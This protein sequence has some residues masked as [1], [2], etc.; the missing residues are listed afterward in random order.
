[1]RVRYLLIALILLPTLVYAQD[2]WG[3]AALVSDDYWYGFCDS[4]GVLYGFESPSIS[5]ND[6]LIF[7]IPWCFWHHPAAYSVFSEGVWQMPSTVPDSITGDNVTSL[8]Y[9]EQ[10]STLYFRSNRYPLGRTRFRDGIWQA[11]DSLASYL[12]LTGTEVDPSLPADGSRL[13]FDRHGTIM[14]S[15]IIDGA[16]SEPVPLPEVINSPDSLEAYP[17]IS[18]DGNKLYFNRWDRNW[19]VGPFHMYVSEQ[20]N[21]VW[22]PAV[23]VDNDV[24]FGDPNPECMN[25]YGASILPSFSLN[26]T[27]MYFEYSAI[28]GFCEPYMSIYFSELQSGVSDDGD[29]TPAQFFLSAY[30]NPFNA[31]VSINISGELESIS[32]LAIYNIAGQRVRNLPVAPSVIWDGKDASRHDMASGIYFVRAA[33]DGHSRT[34]KVALVR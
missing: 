25:A 30:P 15:D 14:Y 32:E 18:S 7:F 27:K 13:Y 29:I 1:V 3:P 12:Y 6:S 28:G 10:D 24:N 26:G 9:H 11:A 17:R 4:T 20:V 2:N 21:G 22:Q 19:I 16:F 23:K 8:F 5:E 34:I 33:G 31:E